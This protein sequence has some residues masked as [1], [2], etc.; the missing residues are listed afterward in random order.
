M[1]KRLNLIRQEESSIKYKIVKFPYG[2]PHSPKTQQLI[3]EYC[4]N[5][6]IDKPV[7]E[8]YITCLPDNGDVER[9]GQ[10]A[11]T[12]ICSNLAMYAVGLK[13]LLDITKNL[14]TNK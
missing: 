7:F 10:G 14:K 8:D 12:L 4:C 11:S 2:E 6:Q 1:T 3:E 5:P 9:I 13:M